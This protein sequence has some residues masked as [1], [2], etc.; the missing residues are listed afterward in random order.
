MFTAL[1]DV[2]TREEQLQA[3]KRL[4]AR[5][6]EETRRRDALDFGNIYVRNAATPP[7]HHYTGRPRPPTTPGGEQDAFAELPGVHLSSPWQVAG[8]AIRRC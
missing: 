3:R 7:S 2:V 5:E 4:L 1:P 6:K 8:L